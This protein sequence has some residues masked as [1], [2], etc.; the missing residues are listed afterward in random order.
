M[1]ATIRTKLGIGIKNLNLLRK[2]FGVTGMEYK[3]A[4]CLLYDAFQRATGTHH[5]G[6]AHE[7]VLK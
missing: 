3:A 6:L 1:Q 2:I 7:H 5:H 4:P